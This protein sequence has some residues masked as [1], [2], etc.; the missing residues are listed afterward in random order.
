MI[1]KL[2]AFALRM[3]FI[4][5][6]T[7]IVIVLAGFAAY[8]RLDIEA[9]PNPVPPLVEIITQPDGWSAEEVE[10]YV[11]IPLE[12]GLAGMPGLDHMRSQSIFG[13]SDVKCYFKWGYEYK[14]VRQEVIN[15]IQFAPLPNGLQ[16]QLSPWNAIGEIYRYTLQGKGYTIRDMKTVEDWILERQFKQV[17]G[18]ID[19]T[20]YGGETKQYHVGVDPIRLRGQG[21]T[22][23]QVTTAIGNAN[24]N[25]GGQRLVIGEQSYNIRGIGL[26]KNVHDIED[27]V[28]A[29]PQVNGK[30]SGI[31][32]RVKDV[33]DVDIGYAPRL[34]IV[35]HDDD[36]DVVQ[37]IVLMRYGGETPHALD[38]VHERVEYI[39]NTTCSRRGWSL[40]RTTTAE[41][42][43]RSRRT[44]FSRTCCSGCRSSSSCS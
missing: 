39:R 25:V 35:G 11:T 42:S 34:G 2:V 21:V 28:V 14:D 9:Y 26:I 27:I 44:P 16:A 24:A 40:C 38:G 18:V 41:S 4:I 30:P 19:V 1:Q 7:V 17:D 10:R 32:V 5:V 8:S 23:N 31:P 15:R 36:A 33:A 37:G 13:L 43:S 3:P 22:L 29:E 6:S 20:S 12:I